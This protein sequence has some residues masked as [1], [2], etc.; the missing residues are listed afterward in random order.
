MELISFLPLRRHRSVASK[1]PFLLRPTQLLSRPFSRGF[2]SLPTR[3]FFHPGLLRRPSSHRSKVPTLGLVSVVHHLS[4]SYQQASKRLSMSTLRSAPLRSAQPRENRSCQWAIYTYIHTPYRTVTRS[5]CDWA[6][7]SHVDLAMVCPA[8]RQE[9]VCPPNEKMRTNG[10]VSRRKGKENSETGC[11]RELAGRT[12]A[13]WAC[14]W[15]G[16]ERK[17]KERKEGSSAVG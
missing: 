13:T 11:R 2:F 5:M 16:K 10:A 17:G 7:K 4:I 9:G 14:L 8:G 3:A 6:L 12:D 15:F 1:K